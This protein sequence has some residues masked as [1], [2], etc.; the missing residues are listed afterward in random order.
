MTLT[1]LKNIHKRMEEGRRE[2]SR[3]GNEG[4]LGNQ[5]GFGIV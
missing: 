3:N 2:K 4:D 5:K 1:K